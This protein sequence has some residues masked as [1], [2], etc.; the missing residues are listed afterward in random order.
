MAK[1]VTKEIVHGFPFSELPSGYLFQ[2]FDQKGTMLKINSG[3]YTTLLGDGPFPIEDINMRIK[4]WE[5]TPENRKEM[6]ALKESDFLG[7]A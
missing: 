1:E 6:D 7:E 3:E 2:F 4:E 5:H